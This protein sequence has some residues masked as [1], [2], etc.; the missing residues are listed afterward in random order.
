MR[1]SL[2]ITHK[3]APASSIMSA[4]PS[5]RD[6]FGARTLVSTAATV[7]VTSFSLFH[8]IFLKLT[9]NITEWLIIFTLTTRRPAPRLRPAA[10]AEPTIIMKTMTMLQPMQ[11]MQLM[12]LHMQQQQ[13]QQQ[14]LQPQPQPFRLQLRLPRLMIR[15]RKL[16]PTTAQCAWRSCPP[17]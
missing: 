3:R 17:R 11:S 4:L 15:R 16:R 2:R 12:R 10:A 14:L 8:R 5:A 6:N 7:C 13:L 1:S 9:I